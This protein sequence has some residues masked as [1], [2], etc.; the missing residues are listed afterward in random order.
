MKTI[1]AGFGNLLLGDDGF[2]VEV[3]RRFPAD[4]LPEFSELI[5]VGIGGFDLVLKLMDGFDRVIFVDAV[6]RNEPPGTLYVFDPS[7]DHHHRSPSERID[8]HFTEPS[9]AIEMARRLSVLPAELMFIG[10]EP[11]DCDLRLGLSEPVE[12]AVAGAIQEIRNLV[13]IH[14]TQ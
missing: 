8:P 1:I 5:E 13:G 7:C 2:G 10:C 14:A 3:V 4:E 6:R 9:R 11:F 12:A